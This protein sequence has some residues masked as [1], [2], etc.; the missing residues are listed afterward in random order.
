MNLYRSLT[1]LGGAAALVATNARAQQTKSCEIDESKPREVATANFMVTQARSLQG[2]KRMDALKKVVKSLTEKNDQANPVGRNYQLGKVFFTLLDDSTTAPRM[3][4]GDLGFT[5]DVGATADLATLAD[6]TMR[7]VETAMP[8]CRSLTG[9]WRRQAG[10]LRVTQKA[11]NTFNAGQFDSSA[12]YAQRSL[13]LDP[14]APYA[15]SILA[16]LAQRNNDIPKA[17]EYTRQA[18]EAAKSDTVFADQRRLSLFNLGILIGSQAEAASGDQQKQL[19]Q[20]SATALR[21]FLAEAK[22]SDENVPTARTSL[23]R[24][25]GIAGDSAGVKETYAAVLSNPSQ[26]T[27]YELV[28]AGLAASRAGRDADAITL[29]K[30]AVEQNPNSRDALFNLSASSFNTSHYTEMLPYVKHL[31]ELDPNN[32]EA[33]R[34]MAGAYQGLSKGEKN[35]KIK[36]ALTDTLLKAYE[37]YEKMPTVVTIKSFNKNPDSGSLGGTIENRGTTPATYNVTVEFLDKGGNVVATKTAS[38]GPV[39]PKAKAD[40]KV[41]AQAANIVSFR[42]QPIK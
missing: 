5:T 41:E 36:A 25:L 7:I 4:R 30:V 38:V 31:V 13:Q 40:F 22:S 42:Y 21:T 1:A 3:T 26:Y 28:Q 14:G 27:E 18:A 33:W 9:S 20:Q 10:W 39:A 6:S 11:S 16:S 2:Q 12:F 23:A 19:A 24:M 32:P 35:T 37:K 8:E 15:Y 29:F 17:V 34:V